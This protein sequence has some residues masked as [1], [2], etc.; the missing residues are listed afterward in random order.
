METATRLQQL[1][2]PEQNALGKLL[3]EFAQV[4]NWRQQRRWIW[5]ATLTVGVVLGR[6]VSLLNGT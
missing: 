1:K 3:N 5:I 6:A 2:A 4:G